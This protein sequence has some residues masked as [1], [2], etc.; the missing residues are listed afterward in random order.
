MI[1]FQISI[2][3]AV[4][5]VGFRPF[6]F[7]LANNLGVKGFVSN[8]LQGVMIE[9]EGKEESL[10]K[11]I[12]RIN[13]D[14]PPISLI[15]NISI[16]IL[17]PAN[18]SNFIIKQ[19][20]LKGSPNAFILPDIATCKDCYDEIF[21]SKDRRYL[22]PF[23]NCTNCGPR[24]SITIS[25][26]YDRANTTMAKFI[27]CED[28]LSEYENPSDRRFHA[29]PNACPVCGPHT[30][31][32]NPEGKILSTHNDSILQT[33][34]E[35]KNGRILAIKGLGG[36]QIVADAL[37]DDAINKLRIHKHR[38]EKPFALMYP[39][40]DS[41]RKDCELSHFEENLLLSAQ[42]PIVI[43]KK[44]QECKISSF[45]AP[46]NPNL[47]IMLP[48]TPLHHLMMKYLKSPIIAT[49]GNLSE[50]PIC[51][52]ELEALKRLY[53]IAD[54]FLVHNRPIY[55]HVDDSIVREISEQK[56]I[57]RRS[58]GFAPMPVMIDKDENKH[59]LSVGGHLKN[60]IAVSRN[61]EVFISQH[62][63]DLETKESFNC[64]Q[65]TIEK[66]L[67]V[68]KIKPTEVVCDSHPDYISAKYARD[69]FTN[70]TSVQHH[71]AHILSVIAERELKGSLLG[72]AWDG[73]G[74][75]MDKSIWGGEFLLFNNKSFKR[76][77]HLKKFR[78]PGG[79]S[80]F[81]DIKKSAFGVLY[82]IFGNGVVNLDIESFTK[83]E[84]KLYLQMLMN[85][86]NSPECSSAGRL[87]DAV[88]SIL[89]IRQKV[90]FEGQ[91]AMELEFLTDGIVMNDSYGF[92]TN[93]L[94]TGILE[95][96]WVPMIEQIII[97]KKNKVPVNI[98]SVK[99]HNTLV[100]MIVD[101]ANKIKEK[102]IA[103]SGGCFQ[104]KYLMENSIRMLKHKG[105][106][107]YWNKEVPA[108]D[109][110]I[111]LGQIAYFS[112][113]KKIK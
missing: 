84:A 4:Q 38:E 50:E 94:K 62:I 69:N 40:I 104:N 80:S 98:I 1:R 60:T 49:S 111:S 100:K 59:I 67:E 96:N 51:I 102:N 42:A 91:A 16:S 15:Q 109:G 2:K 89:N 110:G 36:F 39:D 58:R 79:E 21:N 85:N 45:A 106:N 112:Y 78:L 11:F 44:K 87:F 57:L 97:D 24:F 43:L 32:W 3:G 34:K 28:C 95:I 64:F 56:F 93:K 74:Y 5:G 9:A 68:Y 82:E 41:V 23:T 53:N 14:K 81:R 20:E 25:L 66:F 55:R 92:I 88:A 22:Y 61:K 52:D 71:A 19:S 48:Y 113:F 7:K 103:L 70:V 13:N 27:M 86:I 90:N 105:Y 72:I 30:E 37:N 10:K 76:V 47:G 63:G 75:G 12:E 17:K 35:I 29:Q 8:T 99:F 33:V 54:L 77:A 26:P 108:N 101:V 46:L 18:H 31:L 65:D 107:V 73:A 83:K 6:I